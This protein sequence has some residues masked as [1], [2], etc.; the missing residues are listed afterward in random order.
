MDSGTE[1]GE[2]DDSPITDLIAEPLHHDRLIC[3]HHAGRLEFLFEIADQVARGE[4]VEA[5]ALPELL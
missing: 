5:V 2:Q 1:G 3:G 4:L